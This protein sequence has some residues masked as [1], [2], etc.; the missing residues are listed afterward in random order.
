M[1]QV[2]PGHTGGCAQL[3]DEALDLL[4]HT[5]V[6][7]SEVSFVNPV[8]QKQ[9]A[10]PLPQDR[11]LRMEVVAGIEFGVD[12]PHVEARA[13]ELGQLLINKG[14]RIDW[15]GVAHRGQNAVAFAASFKDASLGGESRDR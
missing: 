2:L 1:N 9:P 14:L 15:E 7:K 11:E 6:I 13:S 12:Q 4:R 8:I 3:L 5:P 10:L